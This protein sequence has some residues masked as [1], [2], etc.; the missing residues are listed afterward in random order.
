MEH[1]SGENPEV[2]SPDAEAE[3]R[4]AHI[5]ACVQLEGSLKRMLYQVQA[6]LGTDVDRKQL[7]IIKY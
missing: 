4:H 3:Y 6:A 2:L 7:V 5:W 1:G